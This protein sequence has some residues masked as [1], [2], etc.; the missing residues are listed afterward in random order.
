[1]AGPGLP[2]LGCCNYEIVLAVICCSG[3]S[4]AGKPQVGRRALQLGSGG[5]VVRRLPGRLRSPPAGSGHLT[6]LGHGHLSS[7]D[8]PAA[9][10]ELTEASFVH[11]LL[12]APAL[13]SYFPRGLRAPSRILSPGGEAGFPGR[14]VQPRSPT[15]K[16][17]A[18][19]QTEDSQ[20]H[21]GALPQ[22][23]AAPH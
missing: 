3:L 15:N 19:L 21:T 16:V 11:Y 20:G 1:M 8:W 6:G 9:K 2:Q 5:D 22:G 17:T 4:R 7:E 13:T 14:H 12:R 10:C 18:R 23:L